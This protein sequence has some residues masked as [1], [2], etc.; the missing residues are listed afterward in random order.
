MA[1]RITK[2]SQDEPPNGQHTNHNASPRNP[3]DAVIYLPKYPHVF[4]LF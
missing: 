3:P 2:G 4:D 1:A